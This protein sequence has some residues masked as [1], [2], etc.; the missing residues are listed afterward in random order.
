MEGC[1]VLREATDRHLVCISCHSILFAPHPVS[2]CI[3]YSLSILSI[4]QANPVMLSNVVMLSNPGSSQFNMLQGILHFKIQ[5]SYDQ[6]GKEESIDG[7]RSNVSRGLSEKKEITGNEIC[8]NI[9]S[10]E[11]SIS[12]R[13]CSQK[14]RTMAVRT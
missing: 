10:S 11:G 9:R 5:S 3:T 1:E 2:F 8:D 13:G 14:G 7:I 6:N 4:L 12:S